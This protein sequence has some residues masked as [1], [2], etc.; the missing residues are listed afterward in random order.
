MN[1]KWPLIFFICASLGI[2]GCKVKLI[3]S[4]SIPV[5]H[6]IWDELVHEHVHENGNVDY[7]GF[8][9]DSVRLNEYL[10]ILSKSHPNNKNWSSDQRMA[11]WIN[12]YN[13]FTVQLVIRNYPVPSIKDIRPGI[14]FVNSVWDIKFIEIEGQ[15]YD[16]NNIEH[17]ILRKY[18]KE[19]RVHFALNCASVSCPALRN[20]AYSAEKLEI[21]LNDQG[22]RFLS[23]PIKNQI[24]ES[25]PKISPIFKWFKGDFTRKG[26]LIDFLNKYS[27]VE[28]KSDAK[29]DHM[30]YDWNLNDIG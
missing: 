13:A 26:D 9:K 22:K 28:I 18:W 17:G 21:Q 11:Y 15:I 23:N 12:A 14:A 3:D 19:P 16:L 20:E 25:D 7:K 10:A 24:S 27:P 5:S 29:I 2:F 4:T 1:I 6:Q 8:V 30:S